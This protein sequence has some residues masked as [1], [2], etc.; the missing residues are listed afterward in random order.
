MVV[1]LEVRLYTAGRTLVMESRE[2]ESRGA[3]GEAATGTFAGESASRFIFK[4]RTVPS[5]VGQA[6]RTLKLDYQ[7]VS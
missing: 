1:W 7:S 5:A 6:I 2:D 4:L 3:C